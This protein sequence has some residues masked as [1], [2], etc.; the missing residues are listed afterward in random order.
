MPV[1]RQ[2]PM[3]PG[4]SYDPPAKCKRPTKDLPLVWGAEAGSDKPQYHGRDIIGGVGCGMLYASSGH[5]LRSYCEERRAS[6]LIASIG[7]R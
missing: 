6:L 5:W 7:R 2:G 3:Y 1:A 4:F